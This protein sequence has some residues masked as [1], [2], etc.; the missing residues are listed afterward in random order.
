MKNM[1]IAWAIIG[2]VAGIITI[3]STLQAEE[4]TPYAQE[5]W[6]KTFDKD[7]V[8]QQL[9]DAGYLMVC[10]DEG[11]YSLDPA[12]GNVAWKME[13]IKKLPE[14]FFEI[15]SGTQFAV[16]SKKSGPLGVNTETVVID[17]IDGKILWTS[18]DIGLASSSGQL[19]IPELSA[20]LI[21]GLKEKTMKPTGVLAELMTGKVIWAS[22]TLFKKSPELY[23]LRPAKK[24]SR[25][26]ISGNQMPVFHKDG[27]IEFLTKN[28]PRKIN[29]TSGEVIWT[30]P[31]K[32]KGIPGLRYGYAPFILS[33]DGQVI[34][35]PYDNTVAA[36]NTND[37]SLLWAK[38]PKLLSPVVQMTVTPQGLVVRG[39]GG[40]KGKPYINILNL[41][42]GESVW[43]KPFRDMDGAS[44]FA[45][46]DDKIILYADGSIFQINLADAEAVERAKKI[47]FDGN[48]SPGSLELRDNG[49]LLASQQNL[50]LYDGGG[51][52]IYHNYHKAPGASLFAKIATTAAM[53][54]V[55]AMSAASAYSR[56]AETGMSQKYEI[57]GNPTMSKRFKASA[58]ADNYVTI[59]CNI[60]GG[61]SGSKANAGLVKIDKTTGKDLRRVAL[62]TKEPTYELDGIENRLF[63]M[64]DDRTIVCYD[65]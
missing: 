38:P 44:S 53:A 56:A 36:I 57:Y 13:D 45:V 6:T 2:L 58:Q 9:T 33:Q 51:A 20:L 55:N 23:P 5:L 27:F 10:T 28:G 52:Q 11:L 14:D 48:E 30:S 62:G 12:T 42:T 31:L 3:T 60:E 1:G 17:A 65:F 29:S 46:K 8:W 22:E 7:I 41:Q 61:S 50:A 15:L 18:K 49:F 32:F 43:K 35:V 40:E 37:G 4:E 21:Y 24:S 39:G 34:Y 19:F 25:L 16:I 64:K 54:G 26:A 63:F 47:K 59:L